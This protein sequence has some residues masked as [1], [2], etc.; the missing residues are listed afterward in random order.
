ML[1][2]PQIH[3]CN[4]DLQNKVSVLGVQSFCLGFY[5]RGCVEEDAGCAVGGC[6]L[7][8]IEVRLEG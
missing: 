4:R 5:G 8:A 6:G 2:K 7:R 3:G 1:T